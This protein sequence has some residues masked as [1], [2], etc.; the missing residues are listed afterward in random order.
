[1]GVLIRRKQEDFV[2]SARRYVFRFTISDRPIHRQEKG[3][4]GGQRCFLL[5][6]QSTNATVQRF[7]LFRLC[8]RFGR[9][10]RIQDLHVVRANV[11]V[12]GGH[13]IQEILLDSRWVRNDIAVH[14]YRLR[15]GMIE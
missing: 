10:H 1:M 15:V 7:I 9:V 12:R 5:G 4:V 3:D 11:D 8:P 13:V 6:R 14:D 2:E